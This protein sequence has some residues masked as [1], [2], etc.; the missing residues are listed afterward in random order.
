MERTNESSCILEMC[1]QLIS[2]LKS[3]ARLGE[4][5]L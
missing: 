4:Q 2:L 5:R 1:I 3:C